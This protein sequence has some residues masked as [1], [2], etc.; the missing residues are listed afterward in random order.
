MTIEEI[1]QEFIRRTNHVNV[2]DDDTLLCKETYPESEYEL[3]RGKIHD[4]IAE[5]LANRTDI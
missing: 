2:G 3:D 1:L 4:F 5:L